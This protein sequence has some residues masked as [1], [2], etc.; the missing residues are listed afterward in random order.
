MS[1][2]RSMIDGRYRAEPDMPEADIISLI[3]RTLASQDAR[4]A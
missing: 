2:L 3:T 4:C 1:A